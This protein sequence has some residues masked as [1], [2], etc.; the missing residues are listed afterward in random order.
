MV[1]HKNAL[2]LVIKIKVKRITDL[3]NYSIRFK[4]ER[5]GREKILT[6]KQRK[7]GLNICKTIVL[8]K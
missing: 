5:N 3:S 7:T 2:N 1:W 8:K 4:E 6:A